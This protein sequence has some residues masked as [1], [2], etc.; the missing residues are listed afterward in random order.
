MIKAEKRI[1]VT[2]DGRDVEI[3][4]EIAEIAR[5]CLAYPREHGGKYISG[6]DLSD[7]GMKFRT[8]LDELFEAIR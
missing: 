2:F 4:G 5:V 3:L 1:S 7:P 6:I 8:F